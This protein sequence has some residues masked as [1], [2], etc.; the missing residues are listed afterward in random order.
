MAIR[1]IDKIDIKGKRVLGRFDFNVPLKDGEIQDDSRILAAL[2]TIK[3][4]LDNGGRLIACS[5]LGKPK[6]KRVDELSLKPVARRLKELLD[7]DVKMADDCIGDQVLSMSNE[8]KDGEIL[9]LENLRFYKGETENDPEFSKELAKLADVYVND[10]FGVVHRKHASV[11]GICDYVDVVCGGFLIKKEVEYLNN[12]LAKP[13]H[14]FVLI[15][16]GVK[17]ST[18]LGLLNNLIDKVNTILIGGAM[19]NTFRNAQGY[20]IGNSIYEKDLL[21]EALKIINKAKE[22]G[23]AFYLPVDYVMGKDIN[24]QV[25]LGVFPYQNVDPEGKIFDTGPATHTLYSEVLKE[26]KTVVWNGPMGA[27]E[28]PTFS[29]GSFGI[30]QSVAAVSGTTI[31]GGGDTDNLIHK[32]KLQDKITFIS[33]G[34][35]SFLEFLE[36]KQLPGLKALGLYD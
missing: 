10:A 5:H 24:D 23:V 20:P 22:K 1:F 33:T 3:Y 16:G 13:E 30:A 29:Q 25:P 28:N 12:Y 6:G 27:F 36:G 8:L 26:A 34:G 14:P 2:D 7:K 32:C 18:K 19:A 11:V 15:A 17:V 31:V 21:D 9:L 4:I 35:G